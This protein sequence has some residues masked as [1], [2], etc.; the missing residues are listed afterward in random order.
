MMKKQKDWI[1][2]NMMNAVIFFKF[3]T[4][5]K[6]K[7][8]AFARLFCGCKKDNIKIIIRLLVPILYLVSFQTGAEIYKWV[9]D[10]GVVHYDDRQEAGKKSVEV[11]IKDTPLTADGESDDE[12][13]NISREEKRQR[14]IDALEEDRLDKEKDRKQKKA[15][16]NYNRSRCNALKDK[17]KRTKKATGVYKLDK[18]G[19]RVFMSGNERADNEK[20][21]GRE[22]KKYCK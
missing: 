12:K 16:A 18:D 22:I 20:M 3:V 11:Q 9:D 21:L 1:L 5:L 14:I 17:M 8:R 4:S 7:S 10:K 19:N 2:R 6:S 13:E 15:V